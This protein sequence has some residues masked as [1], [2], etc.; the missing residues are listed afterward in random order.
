MAQHPLQDRSPDAGS[1]FPVREKVSSRAR[2][3]RAGTSFTVRETG[4]RF[5]QEIPS[6]KQLSRADEVAALLF[7]ST[8]AGRD[9]KRERKIGNKRRRGAS[10]YSSAAQGGQ[11]RDIPCKGTSMKK[12]LALLMALML[13]V[14]TGCSGDKSA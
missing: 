14:F 2:S 10:C 3:C 13:V 4:G 1:L 8:R 9:L 7:C 6:G 11:R 12:L 5:Q